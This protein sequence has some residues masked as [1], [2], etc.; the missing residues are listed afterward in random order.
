MLFT[1]TDTQKQRLTELDAVGDFDSTMFSNA[2]ERDSSFKKLHDELATKNKQRLKKLSEARRRPATR[3]M[4][5]SLVQTLNRAGFVEVSTPTT[6][7]KGMLRKMGIGEE[8]ALWK[9]VYWLED[10]NCLRPMLAPNLYFV[11]GY[12]SKIM[13]RPIRI[14]EVGPCF[15]KESKGSRHLSEFTMLNLVE[16]GMA[17]NPEI[18]VVE[19]AEL[20]MGSLGMPYRLVREESEV[21]KKTTDIMVDDLEVASCATG[22]HPLDINWNIAESWAGIGFGLERLVMVR[23]GFHNIRRVGRSLIYMDGARLN[24]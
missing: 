3:E 20:V 21:Y 19:L 8:H 5:S 17:G 11:L 12:L 22:P 6:L 4:E 23:E 9:Q 13:I 24:V 2:A 1:Y 7:S 18:R 16:M 10:G 15:R 14:F